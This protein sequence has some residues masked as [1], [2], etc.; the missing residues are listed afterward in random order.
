VSA[1]PGPDA[2]VFDLDGVLVDSEPVWDTARR[3]V[4][5]EAGGHWRDEATRAMMGMSSPEWSRYMS[6]QL[7]V[8]LPPD[9]I[10]R[11]VVA[12]LLAHYEAEG[13]PLLPGATSSVREL[14]AQW[15]LGLA[16]SANRQVID[17]V[18]AAAGLSSF[19]AA[20]VSAE[21]VARGKPA[22]DVYLATASALG[23]DPAR[24]VAVEDSTNG[25]RSAAAAG[26]VVI[27]VPNARFPPAPNALALAR[28]VIGSLTE[29]TPTA[30]RDAATSP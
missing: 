18:L 13:A 17:A 9:E 7:A 16:S 6:E 23:V 25:L 27:A 3:E 29:L 15:P 11:R 8:K 12:K 5:A 14:A 28:F 2:V 21:A 4:A 22:G 30:V 26:L 20:T 19:F 1:A 10:N 24:A